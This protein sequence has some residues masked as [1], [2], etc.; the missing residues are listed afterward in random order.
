MTAGS[1]NS[2][3]REETLRRAL[4]EQLSRPTSAE[5]ALPIERLM[6]RLSAGEKLNA[7]EYAMISQEIARIQARNQDHLSRLENLLDNS[8]SGGEQ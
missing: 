8:V 3:S 2:E 1:E 5:H 4:E 6:D 7:E